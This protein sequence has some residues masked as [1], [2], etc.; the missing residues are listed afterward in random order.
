[1]SLTEKRVAE[2]VESGQLR[3]GV[4]GG[5]ANSAV[6]RAHQSAVRMEGRF[7]IVA[8]HFSRNAAMN[9]ESG[10]LWGVQSSRTYHSLTTLLEAESQELD[11]IIVLSPTPD[12]FESIAAALKCGLDVISEKPVVGT[13]AQAKLLQKLLKQSKRRLLI[14]LNYSGYPMVR[15]LQSLVRSGQLGQIIRA[16]V[17]MPQDPFVRINKF[18]KAIQPQNWRLQNSPLPQLYLDLG[19]H[20]LHLVGYITAQEPTGVVASQRSVGNFP[21]VIDD[22]QALVS[23]TNG[24]EVSAWFSKIAHGYR[25]GLNLR[26]FGTMGS[27]FWVQTNPEELI[28]TDKN[29][30]KIVMDRANEQ[31]EVASSL[32][33]TRFK[34]GHPSGFVEALSNLYSDFGDTL[35]GMQSDVDINQYSLQDS[36]RVLE[37]LEAMCRSAVAQEWV[38][39]ASE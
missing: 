1:L 13:S 29:G 16:Q 26:I 27:A 6:G 15:Q 28:L 19:S 18:D 17:E 8:G 14:T 9:L 5:G 12:H 30:T 21:G 36:I 32:R 31:A 24:L 11:L 22:V 23:Y 34:A 7:D 2:P 10:Q 25:N 20:L 4:I 39:L 33:Y 38:D 35:L 3:V 37:V